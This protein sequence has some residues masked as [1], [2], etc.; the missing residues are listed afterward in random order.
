MQINVRLSV[1][2]AS[3]QDKDV[4]TSNHLEPDLL[5]VDGRLRAL[6]KIVKSL[7]SGSRRLAKCISDV[8]G[9]LKVAVR[10]ASSLLFIVLW[11][12]LMRKPHL[13]YSKVEIC[14]SM[15]KT[16]HRTSLSLQISLRRNLGCVGNISV[17]MARRQRKPPSRPNLR[18]A[19]ES[20]RYGH[21]IPLLVKNVNS[22]D[23]SQ[24]ITR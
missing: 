13:A 18:V 11:P 14:S 9:R 2:A 1:I 12:R 8:R 10:L 21:D 23:S 16:W 4:Q 24:H 7:G 3:R 5:V 17:G 6:L 19:W 20:P 22:P 15:A